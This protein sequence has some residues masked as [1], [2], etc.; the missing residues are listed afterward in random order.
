M[1]LALAFVFAASACGRVGFDPTGDGGGSAGDDV[2]G[3]GAAIGCPAAATFCDDFEGGSVAKWDRVTIIPD[4]GTVEVSLERPYSG[5]HA[6]DANVPAL[7]NGAQADISLDV[8]V[9]TTGVLAA[10]LWVYAVDT[11][12]LFDGVLRFASSANAN[13]YLIV[14]CGTTNQWAATERSPG[15]G[16]TDHVSTAACGPNQ[17][18]C[19]EL[20]YS[21]DARHVALLV[22]GA[23]VVDVTV[24]DPSPAFDRIDVGAVRAVMAGF[25]VFV[26]DVAIGPQRLGC[27]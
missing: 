26:D 22:D 6:L 23:T 7:M 4:G 18:A 11:F 5:S 12:T 14:A 3:D 20:V 13:Q 1:R 21:L 9:Q 19:V 2:R 8:P 16:I 10:R 15:S 27:Q 17:W 24:D 25:R